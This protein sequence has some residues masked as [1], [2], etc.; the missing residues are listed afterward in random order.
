MRVPS[1]INKN[2]L[3]AYEP[4]K[5]YIE[6]LC[7]NRKVR[8]YNFENCDIKIPKTLA[9]LCVE[10]IAR[11]WTERPLLD[12][13]ILLEDRFLLLDLLPESLPLELTIPRIS[14]E[15]YW[16]KCYLIRW[17]KKVAKIK[18]DFGYL[19]HIVRNGVN[20]L[21]EDF[22]SEQLGSKNGKSSASG[23][24][25]SKPSRKYSD[26]STERP[27]G[28]TWKKI[29]CEMHVKDYLERL[30]PEDYNPEKI[31]E[32]CDLF[33]PYVELLSIEE[34]ISS[35]TSANK[36]PLNAVTTGF[37]HLTELSLRFKQSYAKGDFSWSIITCS[38]HDV[39][40]LAKGLERI[41]LKVLRI[42]NSD[43]ECEKTRIILK[44]LL[45]HDLQI[46]D[47]SHCKIGNRGATTLA[48]FFLENTLM[49]AY[50]ANN[51]IGSKGIL[52]LAYALAQ[53]P[54]NIKILDVH[55]NQFSN[56]LG[57]VL[58]NSLAHNSVAKSLSMSGCGLSGGFQIAEAL[59][60]IDVLETLDLSNNRLG[61]DIGRKILE[62]L[63]V[64]SSLKKLDIRMCKISSG[65]EADIQQEIY[66]N[67]K[68]VLRSEPVEQDPDVHF[69]WDEALVAEIEEVF[70][71]ER[72]N[73]EEV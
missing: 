15:V 9:E 50:L 14:D 72:Y 46:L 40:L 26:I 66:R 49:E 11:Y 34:M 31:K 22:I 64:N 12:E 48:K 32:L 8:S 41:R 58:I 43:I 19:S 24:K 45:K 38:M 13:I 55:L 68:G 65:L 20:V 17:P 52:C 53:K 21:N 36:M 62:A 7:N 44:S 42:T 35:E 59:K 2:C 28:R 70:V 71:E 69:D 54:C 10:C 67:V 3:K 1:T 18:E 47:F 33:G 6:Q 4:H 16:K 27:V 56:E 25:R 60:R 57:N 5:P 39:Q 37:P 73:P 29:Y 30:R 63:K 61:E 51:R 23:S